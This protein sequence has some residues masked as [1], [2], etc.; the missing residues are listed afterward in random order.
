MNCIVCS[1]SLKSKLYVAKYCPEC[2]TALAEIRSDVRKIMG[3]A[4]LPPA[5]AFPCVDCGKPAKEYDHRYYSLPL[6]IEPVC[7][8][9]NQRRGPALDA[10][11]L[12]Q[13]ARGIAPKIE[14]KKLRQQLDDAER[15]ILRDTLASVRWNASQAAILL[16]ITYRSMRYRMQ[17]LGLKRTS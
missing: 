7:V 12:I 16:K 8:L 6:E 14:P 17:R 9:C 4:K 11:S 13:E 2:R 5:T 3:D 1:K 10:V 15:A